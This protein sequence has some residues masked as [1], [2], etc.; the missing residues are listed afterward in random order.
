[1]RQEGG[2][3]DGN[4][5]SK[6]STFL[7]ELDKQVRVNAIFRKISMKWVRSEHPINM[8]IFVTKDLVYILATDKNVGTPSIIFNGSFDIPFIDLEML[9]TQIESQLGYEDLFIVEFP[10]SFLN[11]TDNKDGNMIDNAAKV[12]NDYILKIQEEIQIQSKRVEFSPIFN[13]RNFLV[14][15]NLFFIL[16]PF[17]DPFNTIFDD[18]IKPSIES[19]PN[20]ICL[21]ADNIYS[22]RPII[23]D[24]W[25]SINEASIIIAELTGRNPNVFYE[26]GIAHTLGKKV[27]LIAQSMD[28]VPFDLK[29]LRCI[30][31]EYTPRGC[32]SL[33][34][35]LRMT[36]DNIRKE[37]NS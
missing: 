23:D 19:I 3:L 18:H 17:S 37:K 5:R 31:Y 8:F 28:D 15:E 9:K 4:I 24:I 20:A 22:N 1:M 11:F 25:K 10:T 35:S 16:S 6:I 7:G 36:I 21:R 27:I 14:N 13:G 33:E 34:D 26:V 12:A 32:K 2:N 29:H 30:Q